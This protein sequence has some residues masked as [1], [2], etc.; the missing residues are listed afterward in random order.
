MRSLTKSF[1]IPGLRLGFGIGSKDTIQSLA[2]MRPTWNINCFAEEVGVNCLV[3]GEDYLKRSVE[4]IKKERE[5]LFDQLS[6]IDGIEPMPSQTNFIL[7]KLRDF[8]SEEVVRLLLNN[9]ILV[10]DCTSFKG[11]GNGYIRVAVRTR[12]EDERLIRGLSSIT[13]AEDP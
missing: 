2:N 7:L 5:W 13:L 3:N 4:L 8:I 1:A 12:E 11:L 6:R 10:R 9:N